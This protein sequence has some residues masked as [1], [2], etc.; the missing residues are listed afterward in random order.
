MAKTHSTTSSNSTQQAGAPGRSESH[1]DWTQPRTS[2]TS[3]S[4]YAFMSDEAYAPV[5][6]I[7]SHSPFSPSNGGVAVIQ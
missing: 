2:Q 1:L 3:E 4:E 5:W 7:Q 6:G